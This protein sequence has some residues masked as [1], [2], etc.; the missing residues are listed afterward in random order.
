[1]VLGAIIMKFLVEITE[2][3]QHSIYV[4]AEN[5]CDAI[6]KV[7]KLYKSCDIVL[8]ADDFI[9]AEFDVLHNS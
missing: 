1:M 7:K 6:F 9:D 3:L 2:T 5:E 8:T 4:E